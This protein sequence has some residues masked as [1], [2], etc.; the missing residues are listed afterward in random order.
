MSKCCQSASIISY[1]SN[2]GL[3][4]LAQGQ[5][6]GDL[7]D[8]LFKNGAGWNDVFC[9]GTPNATATGSDSTPP[10]SAQAS[11]VGGATSASSSSNSN[12]DFGQGSSSSDGFR[13]GPS[14]GLTAL[15]FG[16]FFAGMLQVQ[17]SGV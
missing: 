7:T 13:S 9:S 10:P 6:V 12:G 11:V 5:D 14:F 17:L 15:A 16:M 2:C 3:Y 8:C 4:C 1:Y